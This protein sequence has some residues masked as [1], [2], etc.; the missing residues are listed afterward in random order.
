MKVILNL[1][2]TFVFCA[3]HQ[4]ILF[5]SK[6]TLTT[7][8]QRVKCFFSLSSFLFSPFGGKF[9]IH[10]SPKYFRSISPKFK[11]R[12]SF[13]HSPVVTRTIAIQRI[14]LLPLFAFTS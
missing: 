14:K 8:T 3:H 4:G 9:Y 5:P 13:V 10:T 6:K 12:V 1:V 2:Q 7:K 11:D